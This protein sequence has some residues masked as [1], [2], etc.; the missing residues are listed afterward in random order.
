MPRTSSRASGRRAT[1]WL[2]AAVPILVLAGPAEAAGAAHGLD[3]AALAVG[4]ALPFVGLLLSIALLPLLAAGFWHH[5]YGK[6]ALGWALAFVLP[7][8]MLLG[9]AAIAGEI[10]HIALLDYV[11]FVI[12]LLALFTVTGGLRIQG[13]FTGTPLSNAT[14]LAIGTCLAS[15]MGTTGAAML[16]VRPLLRANGWRKRRSHVF[17]FL[18]FLVANIGGALTPLGDPPLFLGFLRGVPFFW[19]TVHLLAPMLILSGVLLLLFLLLDRWY[20]AGE[21]DRPPPAEPLRFEGLANVPLLALVVLSVLMSGVLDT[22]PWLVIHGVELDGAS[23]LRDLALLVIIL[24]SVALTAREVREAN[25]FTWEPMLEVAKLFAGIFVTI[26]PVLAMLRAGSAGAFGWVIDSV[27]R[28]DGTPHDI[29][30]FWATGIL[31]SFLDNAPTYLVF[32]NSA[33]GDPAV[34]TTSLAT[35]LAAISAGAVFMGANTYIGNAPN[36]MVRSI[37]EAGGTRMPS[38]FGYMAWSTAVLIPLFAL[39]SWLFYA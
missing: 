5:H 28:A 31:S 12:L 17:I 4:W 35:T 8:A 1:A 9:P 7:G 10:L 2:V 21:A 19:P 14:G 30:Y 11:P 18:I 26:I 29:A 6:V 22:G 33:G 20:A 3:G 36:F 13:G 25:G 39:V 16:L 24:L 37:V 23:L 38:F 32:F 15:L 27:S 34:L